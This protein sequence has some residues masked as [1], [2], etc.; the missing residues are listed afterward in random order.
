MT[1]ELDIFSLD[2]GEVRDLNLSDIFARWLYDQWP[3]AEDDTP[4][5]GD[6]VPSLVEGEGEIED[7]DTDSAPDIV[8]TEQE[9]EQKEDYDAWQ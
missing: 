8:E 9:R 5:S 4:Q 7:R 3:D 1:D 6:M 2:P